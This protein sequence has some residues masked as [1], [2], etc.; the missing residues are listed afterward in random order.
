MVAAL[1]PSL[2]AVLA[3]AALITSLAVWRAGES[4]QPQA[5]ASTRSP[6]HASREAISCLEHAVALRHPGNAHVDDRTCL[7]DPGA[8]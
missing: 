6:S 3:V 5:A 2:L 1:M 8:A 4:D 7:D